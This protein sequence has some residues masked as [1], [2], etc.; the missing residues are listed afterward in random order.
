MTKSDFSGFW[1][2][3]E[4]KG[5][6]IVN[7]GNVWR[8]GLLLGILLLLVLIGS[9][10]AEN[11]TV[12][13][14][15]DIIGFD[16]NQIT[17]ETD[18][19]GLLTLTLSDAYGTYRTITR[20]AKRGVTTFMWDGLGENEERLPSGSYTL[21]ALLVTARGNQETQINVTVGKAK[22]AL[23]FALRSSDTLYLDTDDWFC[24]AKPVRTGAVVMDIYAADDLNTKLDTLKKTFGST[25]KVSWNGRVKGK[26]VAEGDYLL[27]FYAESNP[28]YVRDVRVTVKKGERPVIPVAETGSIMPTWDMDDAA[29]WDMMMKPSVVVDIAAVSHQ[30][31]YDKPST[32]GK[33]LGT[34]HGQSQGVEVLKVEG[35]WAYIGAWQHESGGYIEGW[36]PMKRLKTVTPNSDFG[37]VVDKQTQRMKVF[38]RGKCITTLTISTGLAGKNR[39]I[40]ETAAGAF[41]T[42]ERVSD[43]EDSG[44]HY[45]Y[46]IRYDGG[47]LIHQLGYK[48]Q[49][50]KKDFS[51]QE[52]VLGQKGS[53][54]CVRIPRAVDATGVNVYYLWTHLPYG[55]RLFILDDPENRTLQAAAVSNKVQAD[56]S[57]PTDVPAL[58]AD[59]TELV[60]TLGGDAVLGT[61]EYWWND[62]DSLPTYLNQYGMAYPFSGLQSLFAHDDMTFINLE[63][64]LKDDGK[65]GNANK[66]IVW[67]ARRIPDGYVSAHANQARITTFPKNDPENCLYAPDVVSFAREMGYYDGP[68]AD[69]SFCD[70]YAP[71]DFGALRAC[72]ARVW[73]FFRTVADDMD[74]YTDYAMGH[75]K[76]NRMPLWVKPRAKVS[77]KT[78]FDCMRDHYEGTPMDMTTDLGAGGH[79]CPYRWRPMEFEVDGV[80][81]VNERATATQR[82]GFW[83]VAQARPWNP[84]DMGI[85]WFGV[86]DAATSC[87]TPIFC[88]A[89]EVPGCFREDNGSMLEY[90]PTSAFWLFN[91]VTNFAYM[92]YD[93]ISADIRKVADKWE[94]GML[95]TVREV[96]AEAL[97][98]SPKARGKFL[99]AFSTATAQQLF[100][101]WSKLDKYLLV[102]YMDGNVKSEKADVLTFLDGDGGPAHFVDNGNGRNIPDKIQFPGYNE[103]WKR[104][105]AKDN[106][107]ILRVVK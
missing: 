35:G 38:Y 17:V 56:V 13:V 63:C 1:V 43:F 14:E 69:F 5:D 60:L 40:R 87:L 42:V 50:T 84:A 8:K 77:P 28:A 30:K 24:E 23:L 85:L 95:E 100:D 81:Y 4:R 83:F 68:D 75:N 3:E 10:Q 44:Y 66:G 12:R 94:N 51:D 6:A 9:A 16:E 72:E 58:S 32:N 78:L 29:M 52:P 27:R 41:I 79:N 104:A 55:T 102:K 48:A 37:L 62:P 20:E 107:E 39:L 53:H 49:R 70:A 103:K 61:R 11:F 92:R 82:T 46:A 31:V 98:L 97:S 64:A 86:D 22:Q 2:E 80:K 54:G 25:T 45:E 90:S 19:T 7:I 106:G 76:D 71:L 88:S 67:V 96:D 89:Q 18:Q 93:M 91:R 21:H 47:N 57:A 15:K 26:K 36:V 59:E 33:A 99:T 101:R 74:R 65:G 34:L 105:V 73:A